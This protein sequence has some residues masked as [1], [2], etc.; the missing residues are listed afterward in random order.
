MTEIDSDEYDTYSSA[1]DSDNEEDVNINF[2]G[3][4]LNKYII[5]CKIGGGAYSTVWLTYNLK[6]RKFYAIKIQNV[7]DYEDGIEE[8]RYLKKISK[9][10][11]TYLCKMIENFEYKTGYGTHICMVFNLAAGSLF[12]VVRSTEYKDGIALPIVKKIVRQILKAMDA[13]NRHNILH[14]D[15]KPENILIMGMSKEIKKITKEFRSLNFHGLYDSLKKKRKKRALKTAVKSTLRK[16]KSIQELK[17]EKKTSH[18]IKYTIPDVNENISVRLTDFGACCDIRNDMPY[19]IQT[20]YYRAPEIILKHEFNSTCDIWSLG[21]LIYELLTGKLLFNPD[22][23]RGFNRDRHH[24]YDMQMLLGK[25]PDVVLDNSERRN[26]F[27]KQNGLIKGKYV[28]KYKFLMD[29]LS[30]QDDP[31]EVSNLVDFLYKVFNYDPNKRPTARECLKHAWF[32][33]C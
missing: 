5:I 10:K 23:V 13:L 9:D 8:V 28:L 12:N 15:I 20:R 33:D 14:T 19:K 2:S 32:S 29:R 7:D 22:K 26:I 24:L 27:F 18:D 31:K 25:I 1:S 3:I 30:L 16:M 4:T 21:C 17:P 6:K 11:C